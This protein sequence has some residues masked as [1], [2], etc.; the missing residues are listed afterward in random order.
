MADAFDDLMNATCDIQAIG[1]GSVDSYNQ[2]DQTKVTVKTA[3]PCR[4]SRKSGREYKVNKEGGKDLF[5]VYMRP[6]LV[7]DDT[8]PLIVTIKDWILVHPPAGQ[9]DFLLNITNV[10]DPSQVG[11]H[12]ECECEINIA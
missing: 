1:T 11:H 10:S 7:G 6:P 2:P 4:V 12:L 3:W 9:P 8:N 5:K